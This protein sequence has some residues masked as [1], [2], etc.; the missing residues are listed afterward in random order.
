M[1]HVVIAADVEHIE[2]RVVNLPVAVPCTES[3]GHGTCVIHFEYGLLQLLSCRND[4]NVL[5]LDNLIADTPTDD[6]GMVSVA[7]H[8]RMDILTIAR[9]DER[10][11]FVGGLRCSPAIEGLSDNQHTQ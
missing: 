3:L 2:V 4:T 1:N 9:I 5:T 8:H 7:L 10:R 11:V 6:A